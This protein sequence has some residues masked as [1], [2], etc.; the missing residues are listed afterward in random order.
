MPTHYVPDHAPGT[1]GPYREWMAAGAVA[2]TA[3]LALVD[4]TNAHRAAVAAR[5]AAE[6]RYQA[7]VAAARKAMACGVE[8][9]KAA[10]F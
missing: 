2:E 7:A 6:A 8:I 3:R 1:E 5:D 9:A 10:G 4:A